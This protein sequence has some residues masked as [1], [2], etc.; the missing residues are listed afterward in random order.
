MQ[1]EVTQKTI[2]LYVKVGKGAA[3][4]TEQALQK[5][6]QKFLE[7]KSKPAHGKQTMRQLMKQNAGVS[8]IEITD[9]NIKAFES[10]AKKY[11]IDFS[12]KKVK[13][14]QTRYLVFFKGRDADVM[15]AAF[16]EF[17]A[18]K[19]NREKKPS[20]RK[21]LAAAKDKAKQ[22]MSI[23][24]LCALPV[25]EIADKDCILFLWA[26]FPQLKEALQLIKAWGF[27][28]KSVAFVW[29]KQ[30]RKSP[31][32]FYGLG[33]WTRGNAE[34]CLLATKGHPKRQSNKV[35]QFIISPVEQHSKKPDITREKILALMGDLPRIELFARQHTPGW[36]VW[37]NEI[38]SDIRF[39]GKEV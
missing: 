7:Q 27:T 34:I 17:S 6:I 4:L 11:N 10:T 12:L 29:L 26:T 38:K 31:T 9:S 36:D 24:E 1:E 8:N 23:E 14:E 3:R 5:A 2:A 13:G 33:F 39:A 22:L 37:G 18:K 21:A 20:I 35:H 25:K 28:Y 15:T 16:Q 32:W 30:N 19:L